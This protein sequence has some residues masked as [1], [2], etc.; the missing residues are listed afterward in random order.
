VTDKPPINALRTLGDEL[1]TAARAR[2]DARNPAPRPRRRRGGRRALALALGGVAVAGAVAGAG[3]LISVGRETP[4]EPDKPARYQPGPHGSE[5]VATARDP[6]AS[7][8]WGVA[9]YMST[10][11]EDCA[12]AGQLRGSEIGLIERGVF[13]PYQPST[14]GVCR[15]VSGRQLAGDLRVIETDAGTR[16]IVYGR[17]GGDARRVE[18]AH[19]GRTSVATPVRGAFLFVFEGALS[20]QNIKLSSTT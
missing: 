10:R 18:L 3:E 17:V 7:T 16:S 19:N 8:A 13:H 4:D 2:T 14:T 5:V 12:I 9:V 11:R 6:E 20:P 15:D 1:E